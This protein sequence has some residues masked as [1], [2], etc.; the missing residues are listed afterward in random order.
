[1]FILSL[2]GIAMVSL[3]IARVEDGV[4]LDA[5]TN[6]P[7]TTW[8]KFSPSHQ[9][10]ELKVPSP[11]GIM[12]AEHI[13]NGTVI[14]VGRLRHSVLAIRTEW[15]KIH[16]TPNPILPPTMC[17]DIIA[18]VEEYVSIHGWTLN[19]HEHYPTTGTI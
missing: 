19:R 4:Q 2:V 3:V 7:W 12:I 16:S 10:I 11:S 17:E 8:G 15:A 5:L 6:E 14:K 1:M 13:I 18:K 9:L